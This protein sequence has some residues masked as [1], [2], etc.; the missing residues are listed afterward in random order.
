MLF[1]NSLNSNVFEVKL[2]AF[3]PL[4]DNNDDEDAD[5]TFKFED[6]F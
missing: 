3:D 5:L 6:F 4:S 1:F 2:L